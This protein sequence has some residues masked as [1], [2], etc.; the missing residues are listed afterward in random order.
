MLTCDHA[1]HPYNPLFLFPSSIPPPQKKNRLIA[2]YID[3][4]FKAEIRIK[5]VKINSL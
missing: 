2:G 1:L 3:V 5:E 4:G